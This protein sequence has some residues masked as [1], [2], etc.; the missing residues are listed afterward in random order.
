M[1][2]IQLVKMPITEGLMMGTL[3]KAHIDII[4]II[5]YR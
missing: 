5:I 1:K 4:F 2:V 3:C